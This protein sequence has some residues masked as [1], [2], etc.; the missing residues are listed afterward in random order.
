MKV[1]SEIKKWGNSLALRI[2]G[3]M[4]ELPGFTEGGKV[5]VQI[6]EKGILVTPV[7]AK[8]APGVL[9]YSEQFLLADMNPSTT[10]ADELAEL[11]DNEWCD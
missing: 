1:E 4:A 2:S 10:H 3:V 6:S 5:V 8:N 11:D 9:P 7:I